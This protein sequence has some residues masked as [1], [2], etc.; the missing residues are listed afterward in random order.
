MTWGWMQWVLS[1]TSALMLWMMGNKSKWGPRIGLMNQALWII[2]AVATE[3][4][5]LLPGT[6]LYTVIHARNMLRWKD[7]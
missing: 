7:A 6:A 1:G 5:G 2:Y 4:W 3:Q